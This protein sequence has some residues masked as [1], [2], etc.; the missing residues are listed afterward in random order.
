MEISAYV[1]Q[2]YFG[3]EDYKNR[4]A[5]IVEV[6]DHYAVWCYV[7]GVV[8]KPIDLPGKSI[9]YAESAAENWIKGIIPN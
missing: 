6:R 5:T 4:K 8:V 2:E 3:L 9:Y 7:D 1:V